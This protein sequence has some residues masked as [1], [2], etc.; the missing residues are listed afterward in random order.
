MNRDG[1]NESIWQQSSSGISNNSKINPGEI[2]DTVVAGAGITGITTA[3]LL[4]QAGKNVL[5]AEARNVGFGTT[6]GTTAHLN[7]FFDSSY[8]EVINNF[9]LENAKLF[10]QAGKESLDFIRQQVTN[11]SINC[12]YEEKT[13][14]LFSVEERQNDVLDKLVE[15]TKKVGVDIDYINES[16]FPAPYLKITSI[17]GQGQFNPVVYIEG[18]LKIFLQ[19]GGTFIENCRV[20]GTDE[21]EIITVKTSVGNIK[22]RNLV[23][24]THIPP[25]VNILHFKNAPYRS[26]AMAAKLEGDKYPQALG[27]D[28]CDPYHYYRSQKIN[29]EEYLIAGG[30]DHK[31]GHEQNT[32][33]CFSNLERYLRKLFA[34]KNISYK[35]SSQYYIPADGLPYIGHLPG[36]REN[37]YTATGFN[38]NGMMLGTISAIIITDLIV[39]GKNKYK[40]LFNPGRVKPVAGFVDLVKESADVVSHFIGDKYKA[41]KIDSF[42]ELSAGEAKLIKYEGSTMAVYKDENNEVHA[43]NSACTHIKCNVSWNNTEKSWDCPCHGSRFSIDGELLT[44]PARKDLEKINA[45]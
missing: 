6:G 21:E 30:E 43:V 17:S 20:T 4:Q 37:V 25:G 3:M 16:P 31:T 23:Y 19:A 44:A 26:Y 2:Y 22:A 10:A 14:Y 27:Y 9:G 18:L 33:Q 1:N 24:A 42:A 45:E 12:E 28:L 5:L 8:D 40:D 32:E 35:W 36:S 15:G 29:G 11:H 34:I 7:T 39:T 41:K 38:G 13:A